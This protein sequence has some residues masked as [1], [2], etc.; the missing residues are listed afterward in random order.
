MLC[1]CSTIYVSCLKKIRAARESN[2]RLIL[3]KQATISM[4][5]SKTIDTCLAVANDDVTQEIVNDT[6]HKEIIILSTM[7]TFVVFR[8]LKVLRLQYQHIFHVVHSDVLDERYVFKT[9]LLND[10]LSDFFA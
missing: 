8:E 9:L 5:S 1:H 6:A 10:N 4:P 7:L 2:D 3:T